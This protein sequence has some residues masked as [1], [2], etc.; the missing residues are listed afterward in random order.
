[1]AA[2]GRRSKKRSNL[3]IYFKTYSLMG[4]TWLFRLLTVIGN[5]SKVFE[6]LFVIS[7]CFQDFFVTF[8]FKQ[9]TLAVYKEAI[10]SG[11][12]NKTLTSSVNSSR[13]TSCETGL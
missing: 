4:F 2:R 12:Q 8:V 5:S 7:T 6:Y 11:Q 9:E 3:L 1:M 10:L 13:N